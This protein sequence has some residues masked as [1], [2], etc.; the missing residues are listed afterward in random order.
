MINACIAKPYK[1]NTNLILVFH[2][3]GCK[4]RMRATSICVES[5]KRYLFIGPLSTRK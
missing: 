4:E 5:R 2:F 1:H 3:E